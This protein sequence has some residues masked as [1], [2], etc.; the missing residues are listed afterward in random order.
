M[1]HPVTA[2]APA[3]AFATAAD[4]VRRW[5]GAARGHYEVWYLTV[6][7]APTQT[8]YWIRYTLEAPLSGVGEP[9]AQLWFAR[10][11]PRDPRRSFGINRKMPAAAMTASAAPFAVHLGGNVLEHDRARGALAGAGHDV[12]WDL[13]WQPAARTHHHLPDVMYLRGGLGETTVLSPNLDVP[14]SGTITVDGETIRLDGEPGGQTHLWGKKHAF[15]WAWGHCN[16]FEGR[17][18]AALEALTVRLRR[19]GVTLPPLTVLSLYLDGEALSFH[20]FRHAIANRGEMGTGFYRF[21]AMGP[22]VRLEGEFT[23]RPDDM[24]VAPYVDPDGDPSYC[25][26]CCAADLRV[27]VF[28]RSGGRFREAARLVAPKRAA[29]EVAGRTR[30]PL[31]TRDHVT[32]G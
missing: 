18:G 31:V 6:N 21:R 28:R 13:S 29:F 23:A 12:R 14:V 26:N 7:H 3:A 9:Y 4:N 20:Q 8:G 30:D 17:P 24:I 11:A 27:T 16:A 1:K 22:S 15:A 32:V 2:A 5:D 10:F 25:A 19:G